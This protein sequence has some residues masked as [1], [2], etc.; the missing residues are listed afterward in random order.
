M[1]WIFSISPINGTIWYLFFWLTSHTMIISRFIYV[2]ENDIISFF[3]CWE[4]V[5]LYLHHFF[6]VHLSVQ[7]QFVYFH[8][9][10][11]LNAAVVHAWVCVFFKIR[12]SLYIFLGMELPDHMVTLYLLLKGSSL[13]VLIMTVTNY[14]P[15]TSLKGLLF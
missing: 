3:H 13:V 6:Y 5:H 11:V 9:L 1:V 15:Q 7:V 10:A 12:F 2:F 8:V 14:I 4:I